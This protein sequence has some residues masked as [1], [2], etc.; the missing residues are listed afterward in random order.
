MVVPGTPNDAIRL[1][2]ALEVPIP[3]ATEQATLETAFVEL[4]AAES[5]ITQLRDGLWGDPGSVASVRRTVKDLLD[6]RN[7]SDWVPDLP[8]PLA[9]ALR[10]AL[11]MTDDEKCAR[12]LVHFWEAVATFMSGFLLSA[13]KQSETLWYEHVPRL[14]SAV[15]GGGSSFDRAT[16][17]TWRIIYDY[18]AKVFRDE[19]SSDDPDARDRA[20]ALL[21]SPSPHVLE[22]LLAP[23]IGQMLSEANATR[24]RFDGH[25][26]TMTARH[27][28]ELHERLEALSER[29]SDKVGSAWRDFPMARAGGLRWEDGAFTVDIELL[30]DAATP[31]LK[32]SRRTSGPLENGRLY[33][34]GSDGAVPLLPFIQMGAAPEDPQTTCYFYSRR[35]RDGMRLVAYQFSESNERVQPDTGEL[36]DVLTDLNTV[37][38]PEAVATLDD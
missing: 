8:Y 19:L 3:S 28:A 26:A 1:L 38:T 27:A 12:Q 37:V 30:M 29:L 22:R 14:R 9:T 13:L 36:S 4:T 33:M 18:T 17:G 23:D 24:N 16:L 34:L 15:A 10:T 7:L 11:T 35:E 25:G 5:R 20:K 32:E 31:F 2:T 21:G 6:D